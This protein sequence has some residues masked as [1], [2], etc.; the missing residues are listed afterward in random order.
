MLLSYYNASHHLE[1][2]PL[3][4]LSITDWN[5]HN[6]RNLFNQN[7]Q[8]GREDIEGANNTCQFSYQSLSLE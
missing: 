4:T 1:K 5:I 2:D 7:F 3:F 6:L 8:E